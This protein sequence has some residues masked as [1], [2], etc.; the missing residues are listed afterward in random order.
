MTAMVPSDPDDQIPLPIELGPVSNGEYEPAPQTPFLCEAERRLRRLADDHA[1]R[2]GLS[3]RDFLLGACGS[4]A[5]LFVLAACS[6]DSKKSQGQ[7]PGGT[8]TVPK[9]ATTDPDEARAAI[10]GDEFIFDVQTH[11]LD[12]DE[13]DPDGAGADF[14]RAF[15]YADC[16]EG[17]WRDCFGIDH[18]FRELFVRSDTTMAVISAV[19]IIGADNPLSIAV[20]ER[21]KA[22]AKSVCGA[23]DRIFLHGQVNPN[24]GDLE[25][26]LDHM[27]A[28]AAEHPIGA[29]KVYTHAPGG[30]GWFLDDHDP[31]AVQCGQAF[32]DVVRE[33]GPKTVCVHKGLANNNRFSSP[34]DIGPAAKANPDITFVA[35]HSGYDGDDPGPYSETTKNA[36]VNRLIASLD[37]AGIGPHANV[38][39]ELGSTWF[40]AMRNPDEAA[41]VLGKLLQRLGSD[42]VL[43]GTDSIWYGSPQNQI[44][45]FRNF[46]ISNQFQD[47]YG[48]PELTTDVKKQVLGQNAARLYG[49]K[50]P[51]TQKCAATP[52]QVD[53]LRK[54]LPPPR[55][56]GPTSVAQ[57]RAVMRTHG[58]PV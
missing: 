3:R 22:A 49:V 17:N 45:A 39:A 30:R 54:A 10:G 28:I 38:Y 19:P 46:E 52:E 33:V 9:T 35:Y 4:A 7:E 41:H 51:V 43:W 50:K 55:V 31:N 40:R 36:G 23:D 37:A 24:V 32:L 16:G 56:H 15:P 25:A 26:E 29:W 20:M 13:T 27:R 12:F 48:Y 14:G 44:E 11:L 53:E 1:S 42:R 5:A 8:F 6:S 57:A 34:I 47:R 58:I 2:L 18:W 21:A